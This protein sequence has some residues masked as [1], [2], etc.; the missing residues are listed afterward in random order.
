MTGK[1][2]PVEKNQEIE[3]E[4]SGLGNN[5]EGI[6]R[7][8]GFTIMVPGMLPGERGKV[9]IV[10]VRTRFAFGKMIKPERS[11]KDRIKPSCPLDGHCGGCQ[12]GHMSYEAQLEYKRNKVKN[13]LV[14]IGH[15]SEESIE[16]LME[17]KTRGMDPSSFLHYRNKAQ[18]PVRMVEDQAEAGF[19]APRSHRLLPTVDCRIQSEKANELICRIM[20][21][22]RRT[23][24]SV[25]DEESGY[26]LLRH[27]LIRTAQATGQVSVCFVINGKNLPGSGNWCRFMQ[28]MGV[29]GFALNINVENTNVI[30]GRET[31]P[32]Y[33]EL[34]IED[35]ID[36]LTF[37]ISPASF[38]QVNSVQ[39]RELYHCALD[40][41]GLTGSETVWDAYCGT[42]TISL[43]LAQNAER[44]YGV[45]IV[46][47]A[48]VNARENARI[49]HI[50]NAEFYTGKAEEVIPRLYREQG[51]RADVMVVDP[52]RAGCEKVLLDTFLQMQ[53]ERIVYVSCDP[54][55]LARDLDILCHGAAE[56]DKSYKI[57]E[58]R[59]VD[60]FPNTMHV[61]T[62]VQLVRKKP[63]DYIRIKM[64]MEDFDLTQSE[65]KATYDDIKSY[66]QQNH[67]MKV[68][69]LYI[70]QI[71]EK[72]GIKE[73]ENYYLGEEGH[74]VPQCTPEKEEAIV[75]ALKHFQMI[76]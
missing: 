14:H 25:Y 72:Y 65:S 67:G 4:I 37:R 68:S 28:D 21:E 19:Y 63:D 74:H 39:M 11:S 61:E 29:T 30:L 20:E 62:V 69:S 46:P 23:R 32:M 12:L 49:N 44:V 48:I 55:T 22:V 58:I 42:G 47:D 45:E 38:Y 17:K 9:H 18:F 33:G 52:P 54:A 57:T 59:T 1:K 13:D 10:Q 2:A 64:D 31:V 5:G 56:G 75:E 53:P 70:A 26:G 7:Y 36:E 8:K 35:K 71:K 43:F 73:R 41:A 16:L 15:F 6:G 27:V 3:L 24:L 60:M 40:M 51:I 76:S 66:V 34:F 50:E